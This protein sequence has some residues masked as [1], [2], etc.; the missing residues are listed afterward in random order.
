[1]SN[2]AE[3]PEIPAHILEY[4]IENTARLVSVPSLAA[5]G[6]GITETA[7]MVREL[8][9]AEGI[10]TELHE[11]GGAPVVYGEGG[12]PDGPT[13]LFYNHYDV[14]PPEPLELWDS[15]PFTLTERDGQLFARGAADDKGDLAARLAGLEWLLGHPIGRNIVVGLVGR[16]YLHQFD[17]AGGPVAVKVDPQTGPFMIAGLGIQIIFEIPVAL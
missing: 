12:N 6:R 9:E 15:D 7:A 2:T 5:E 13:I 10:R 14:Q 8:L 4:I 17:P 16:G 11:T 3:Q 1:M